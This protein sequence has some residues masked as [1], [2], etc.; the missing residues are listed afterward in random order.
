[1]ASQTVIGLNIPYEPIKGKP[2]KA[3]VNLSDLEDLA[4]AMEATR[5]RDRIE[6]GEK[7]YPH[8]VVRSMLVDEDHPVKAWR[9]YRNLTQTDLAK[10]IGM[11]QPSIAK[12]EKGE[13]TFISTLAR[14]ADAL[15]V[16]LDMLIT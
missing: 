15:D 3:E 16:D 4:G 9:K 14:V 11:S 7:T 6:A 1:M 8:A 5:I 12:I 10:A 2:G 13:D